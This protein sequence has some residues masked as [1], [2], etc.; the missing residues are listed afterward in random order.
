MSQVLEHGAQVQQLFALQVTQITK[1]VSSKISNE[2][3]NMFLKNWFIERLPFG[4]KE[5]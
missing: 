2:S 1:L 5:A 4:K 3:E